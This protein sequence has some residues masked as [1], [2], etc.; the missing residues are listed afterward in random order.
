MPSSFELI[1]EAQ[2][3]LSS[4]KSTIPLV[5]F[6]NS[7]TRSTSRDFW[8]SNYLKNAVAHKIKVHCKKHSVAHKGSF[9][10]LTLHE[11]NILPL[12]LNCTEI[13]KNFLA[14][15]HFSYRMTQK[16]P[17]Q[18]N[19]TEKSRESTLHLLLLACSIWQKQP[20]KT[21]PVLPKFRLIQI[22]R[23]HFKDTPPRTAE[24]PRWGLSN[25]E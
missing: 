13:G 1:T 12:T 24:V 23:L 3:H 7:K 15:F 22:H 16:M 8:T 14:V 11:I 17:S 21:A 18:I 6:Q 19:N 2:T 9:T 25:M 4:C 20:T 5:P 10:S